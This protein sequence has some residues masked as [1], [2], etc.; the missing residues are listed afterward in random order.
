MIRPDPGETV[1]ARR[2][3]GTRPLLLGIALTG[4]LAMILYA[5]ATRLLTGTVDLGGLVSFLA[6]F[7]LFNALAQVLIRRRLAYCLTDRRLILGADREIP[8]DRISG[9][10]VGTFSLT[11]KTRGD[12]Q[13][14]WHR[15][16]ALRS[17]AWLATRL[18]RCRAA[19]SP[20]TGK[21]T[22]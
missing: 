3:A 21:V 4:A 13:G 15:I 10:K 17:P 6:V 9:F 18:N 7:T 11:V 16:H 19:V 12:R 22:A 20:E 1:I 5:L 8:L 2:P 14:D